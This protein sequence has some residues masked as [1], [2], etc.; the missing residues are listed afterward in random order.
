M[1]VNYKNLPNCTDV[2]ME[3][4][5]YTVPVAAALWCGIPENEIGD[6]LKK[7]KEEPEGKAIYTHPYISC[8]KPKCIALNKAILE[9]E[10]RHSREDGRI[11]GEGEQ[12]AAPNRRYIS[13]K[14]LREYILKNFPNDKPETLFTDKERKQ[15]VNMVEYLKLQAEKIQLQNEITKLKTDLAAGQSLARDSEAAKLATDE[16]LEK[17]VSIYRE[18][19]A[20]IKRL[21]DENQELKNAEKPI[22]DRETLLLA[23][24]AMAQAL[25]SNTRL[26]NQA[27]IIAY[28]SETGMRGLS[29]SSMKSKFA[30]ANRLAQSYS[31][32]KSS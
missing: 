28:L 4:G 26:G 32:L 23:I 20:E 24:H 6:E 3:L 9:G 30:D 14:H 7:A 8:L 11:I 1:P 10:L 2:I 16:R 31:Q 18:Q 12:I 29:E 13:G 21:S 22:D 15:S 5:I 27:A 25:Y 17:A 19:K